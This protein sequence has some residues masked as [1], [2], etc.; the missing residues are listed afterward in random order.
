MSRKMTSKSLKKKDGNRKAGSRKPNIERMEHPP[1]LNSYQVVHSTTLR[2]TVTAA[3]VNQGVTP[4]NLLDALLV[5]DTAVHGFQLFDAFKLRFIEI[6]GQ[7]A[8]GTPSTV[9]LQYVENTGDVSVHTDT[10]LGIK[11]AYLKAGPS[12]KSLASFWNITGGNNLLVFTAGAG[13]IIDVHICY[14]TST[15]A[16]TALANVLVGANAGEFYW[17][18]LDGLPI[19]TTNFPPPIGVN[20]R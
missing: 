6:W 20:T 12:R 19:A 5:A 11:P 4:E 3:V 9:E 7:A 14:R 15:A 10:S 17:R 1:Q 2:F 8:L 18:G 16:P 13:S